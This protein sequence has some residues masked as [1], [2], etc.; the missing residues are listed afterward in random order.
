MAKAEIGTR[1][2]TEVVLRMTV[3]E[4]EAVTAL[5]SRGEDDSGEF[6]NL[7]RPVYYAMDDAL[8][9]REEEVRAHYV[10]LKVEYGDSQPW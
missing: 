10:R 8:E 2:V 6:G 7:V 4:A 9:G 3:E 1:T 5:V